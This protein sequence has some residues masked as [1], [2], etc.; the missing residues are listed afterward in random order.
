[1]KKD[2]NNYLSKFYIC[3]WV[4]TTGHYLFSDSVNL[5]SRFTRW[6]KALALVLR[7]YYLTLSIQSHNIYLNLICCS[8]VKVSEQNLQTV[9]LCSRSGVRRLHP[10]AHFL[11]F[12][13]IRQDPSVRVGWCIPGKKNPSR[14]NSF[15]S[16]EEWR[17][18]FYYFKYTLLNYLFTPKIV[19][20]MYL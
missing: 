11:V 5:P 3:S 14:S 8:R 17:S 1:M 12:N 7:I 6:T 16:K 13:N 15:P 19:K 18:W 20:K 2:Y 10:W 9:R 4:L